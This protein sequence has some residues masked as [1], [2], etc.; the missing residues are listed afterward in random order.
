MS[1]TEK[2]FVYQETWALKI[3]E[4]ETDCGESDESGVDEDED[5]SDGSE[6]GEINLHV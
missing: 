6:T 5:E 3:W 1:E 2:V 4:D